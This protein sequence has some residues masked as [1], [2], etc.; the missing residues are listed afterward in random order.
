VQKDREVPDTYS[1]V[2]EYPGFY[3]TLSGSMANAAGTRYHNRAIYGHKGTM[4]FENGKVVVIPEQL[5]AKR[6]GNAE[7]FG[8]AKTYDAPPVGPNAHR[9]HT[10]NFFD[11]VRSRKQPNLHAELGH[12]IMTA[13]RLGVD[14]YRERR[15]KFFDPQTRRVVDR[16]PA[17]PAYE[18][19]GKNG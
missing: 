4:L 12:Q 16:A 8:A 11:C 14:A 15:V 10:D 18:G 7:P 3:I 1:S 19:A 5:A 6:S 9:I 2:I 17:R 13:I